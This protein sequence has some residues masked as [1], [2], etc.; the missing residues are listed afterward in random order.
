MK[1]VTAQSTMPHEY[2]CRNNKSTLTQRS[3]RLWYWLS[4]LAVFT[5]TATTINIVEKFFQSYLQRVFSAV[6]SGCFWIKNNYK[7]SYERRHLRRAQ[8]LHCT[9]NRLLLDYNR[10]PLLHPS[11][12][13][14][15]VAGSEVSLMRR[16]WESQDCLVQWQEGLGISLLFLYK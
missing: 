11:E 4:L 14:H 9:C 3:T 7:N 1:S 10:A 2:I 16:S 13:H 8:G 6:R 12:A 5:A 15:D